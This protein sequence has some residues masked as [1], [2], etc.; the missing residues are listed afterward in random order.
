MTRLLENAAGVF[1]SAAEKRSAM[2]D[3]KEFH[4]EIGHQ[5][6]LDAYSVF[7]DILFTG[8]GDHSAC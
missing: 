1:S 6:A 3:L 4:A 2:P 8:C 7:R 5:Q